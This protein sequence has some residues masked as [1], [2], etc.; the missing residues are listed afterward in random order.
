MICSFNVFT[1]SCL[2]NIDHQVGPISIQLVW[3]FLKLLDLT[4]RTM[5][6]YLAIKNSGSSGST[7]QEIKFFHDVAHSLNF[8]KKKDNASCCGCIKEEIITFSET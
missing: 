6:D 4:F 1:F 8:I 3:I 2:S 5:D 7:W